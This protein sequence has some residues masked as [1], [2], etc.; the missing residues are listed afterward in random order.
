MNLMFIA[1]N[2]LHYFVIFT[3]VKIRTLNAYITFFIF[4]TVIVPKRSFFKRSSSVMKINIIIIFYFSTLKY[5]SP[6]GP[7]S[8]LL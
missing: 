1:Q 2:N 7:Y 8:N 3:A 5:G 6:R 4:Y